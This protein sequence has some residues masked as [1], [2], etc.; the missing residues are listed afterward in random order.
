M[1]TGR[2]TNSPYELWSARESG[3]GIIEALFALTGAP[4]KIVD[5][6]PWEEGP[7]VEKLRRLNPLLQVPVLILPEGDI[8]TESGA[9][10]LLLAERYPEAELA[11]APDDPRRPVFL[12][13]LFFLTASVY[14]SFRYDDL[15]ERWVTDEAA[16]DELRTRVGNARNAML[17][18]LDD[19]ARSPWFL[20]EQM[21][22]LDLYIYMMSHWKPCPDWYAANCPRLAA[23]AR[24]V[25]Q[26]PRLAPVFARHYPNEVQGHSRQE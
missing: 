19:A 4:V 2:D 26:D 14:A 9:I 3:G 22:V 16:K 12:R 21:S 7:H 18:Q 13:W 20:G 1:P 11:P 15:P 17:K 10:A 23:I 8:M 24:R 5:A 6:P 25:V